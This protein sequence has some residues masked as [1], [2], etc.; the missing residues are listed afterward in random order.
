MRFPN[1][2]SVVPPILSLGFPK[3][4]VLSVGRPGFDVCFA[5][6]YIG[7][8]FFQSR[9]R[10]TRNCLSSILLS[11]ALCRSDLDH[12]CFALCHADEY[13]SEE[14]GTEETGS[15]AGD[16]EDVDAVDSNDDDP[17]EIV[18]PEDAEPDDKP[19][20][21]AAQASKKKK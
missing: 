12:C 20:P 13:D 6:E 21:K 18:N 9:Y 15:V 7:Y 5:S 11:T 17:P 1:L 10:K 4:Q 14:T 8:Y 16:A 3:F 19:D 2:T